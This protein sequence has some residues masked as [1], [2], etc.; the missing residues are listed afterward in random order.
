MKCHQ[1]P[2]HIYIHT[3]YFSGKIILQVEKLKR[4]RAN[5]MKRKKINSREN[6]KHMS[7]TQGASGFDGTNARSIHI[8]IENKSRCFCFECVK[9]VNNCS[10]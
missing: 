2:L 10:L 5:E 1:A 4:K 7:H 8:K 3:Y 9:E 6:K